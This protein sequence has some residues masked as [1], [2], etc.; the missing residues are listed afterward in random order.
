M[1]F[2]FWVVFPTL[3]SI[4]I[5]GLLLSGLPSLGTFPLA[6]GAVL[7]MAVVSRFVVPEVMWDG[8]PV[9]PLRRGRRRG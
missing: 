8:D 7:L 4:G 5:I 1:W 6:V 3:M 9:P 2:R